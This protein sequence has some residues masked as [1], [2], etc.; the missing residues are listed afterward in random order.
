MYRRIISGFITFLLT[1]AGAATKEYPLHPL[2]LR[3][4][5]GKI[6]VNQLSHDFFSY[7]RYINADDGQVM[8]LEAELPETTG[9]TYAIQ[10]NSETFMKADVYLQL[11]GNSWRLIGR[12][13]SSYY[14]KEHCADE[15][16]TI[17][18]WN[19]AVLLPEGISGT[20]PGKI[21]IRIEPVK[22]AA[23]SVS[24][25][26]T[27][28]YFRKV[29][30]QTFWYSMLIG[31]FI[32]IL[33][34]LLT[35]GLFFKSS[36]YL[37]VAG[38]TFALT[39]HILSVQGFGTAY[40]W[41]WLIESG[42]AENMVFL[43][44][45]AALFCGTG[46]LL[47]DNKRILP[48]KHPSQV[49]NIVFFTCM[50][51]TTFQFLVFSHNNIQSSLTVI[52]ILIMILFFYIC[53]KT[54]FFQ[55]NTD[56]QMYWL[57]AIAVLLII[58]RQIFHIVRAK[59]PVPFFRI[60][61]NDMDWP[62]SI[63]ILII[64]FPTSVNII[65]RLRGKI[66][67]LEIETAA[68]QENTQTA[69]SRSYAYSRVIFSLM[70]PMTTLVNAI[71]S[72]LS[73]TTPQTR[74]TVQ[75]S[76][77]IIKSLLNALFSLSHYESGIANI[78]ENNE[79][80]VLLPFMMN[81]VEEQLNDIK[82][83][84]NLP[85]IKRG[86]PSSTVVLADKALLEVFFSYILEP[87]IQ[88]A[89]AGTPVLIYIDY[90][91]SILTYSVHITS[92]PLSE[93]DARNIL[94]LDY[95]R[96]ARTDEGKEHFYKIMSSWGI[97]LHIVKRIV[98]LYKGSMSIL[99]DPLGNTFIAQ[100]VLKPASLSTLEIEA[101]KKESEL[102]DTS[103]IS[104]T[105]SSH[106]PPRHQHTLYGEIIL[107]IENNT[108]M[109]TILADMFSQFYKTVSSVNGQE[110]F[111]LLKNFTPDLI[112]TSDTLPVLSSEEL[113]KFCQ[114]DSR[115]CSIP[116]FFITSFVE[117]Q[118]RL[119]LY[120]SGA[121]E[122]I[123]KPFLPEELLAKVN[124]FMENRRTVKNLVL[125]DISNAIRQGMVLSSS[126][127]SSVLPERTKLKQT[128]KVFNMSGE[129][130]QRTAS[131]QTN[132]FIPT[133]SQMALFTAANLSGREI[134]IAMLISQGLTDKDIAV[135]LN[136]SPATVA[137]HNKKIFKKLDIHSRLELI[138]KT[139]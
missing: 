86:M 114:K 34:I 45:L 39:G 5:T 128:A 100:F 35:G 79:P 49:I 135:K 91:K 106:I 42:K 133:S 121:V 89:A 72:P 82:A 75:K 123:E 88:Y 58:I 43:F 16:K 99:P 63:A 38:I 71:E 136:I 129:A 117:T 77:N 4:K 24:L 61:D 96:S 28:D 60:F 33:L 110:A 137:V 127:T 138:S 36:F 73:G 109:R 31:I 119:L 27:P 17:P 111:T 29:T 55:T 92:A 41:P 112:I 122:I 69:N 139:M 134:Q 11:T 50:I 104:E 84:G 54:S 113:L 101:V 21:R 59:S 1:F 90:K 118:R 107:I 98:M 93:Y 126:D 103:K 85:E 70:N 53:V 66:A 125:S 10:F 68:A 52:I 26:P 15:M 120:R 94:D 44:S 9:G 47:S 64:T 8:W 46:A 116:F 62:V 23:L 32:C 37:Y 105:E 65:I 51:T 19:Q 3:D 132:S 124:S 40:L 7:E 22:Y 80:V 81:A 48:V 76:S 74:N 18:T 57:W 87:V 25:I 102:L 13:G 6:T 108:D 2:V 83:R 131:V 130:V 20:C 14:L 78:G 95:I 56:K 115:L 97:Q 12:T 30:R 67:L